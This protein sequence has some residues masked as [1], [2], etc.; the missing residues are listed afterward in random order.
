MNKFV[1]FTHLFGK[2]KHAE[3]FSSNGASAIRISILIKHTHRYESFLNTDQKAS[4]D[5]FFPID[6]ARWQDAGSSFFIKSIQRF[7]HIFRG[8]PKIGI[9]YP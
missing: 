5:N 6:P 7:Q 1:F 2:I 4:T 8:F 3:L 9:P